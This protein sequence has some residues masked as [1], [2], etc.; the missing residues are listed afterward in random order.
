MLDAVN[1]SS[2]EARRYCTHDARDDPVLH[3]KNV[4][5][6]AI[7]PIGPQMVAGFG[8]DQLPGDTHPE[9]RLANAAFEHVTHAQL[10]GD[11]F[12]VDNLAFV[13]ERRIAGD[14]E[15]GAVARQRGGD[16]LNDSVAEVVL[17]RIAAE[18]RERQN[19]DRRPVGERQGGSLTV[20]P[21]CDGRI[22]TLVAREQAGKQITTP[23]NGLHDAMAAILQDFTDISDALDKQIVRYG[24]S[25][26]DLMEQFLFRDR[27]PRV[28]CQ[29]AQ[30]L[31]RLRPKRERAPVAFKRPAV[32][33]KRECL[34]LEHARKAQ[35]GSVSFS[36]ETGAF[37]NFRRFSTPFVTR[38]L[39]LAQDCAPD[40]DRQWAGGRSHAEQAFGSEGVAGRR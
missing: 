25:G 31:H 35:S 40:L 21:D 38:N 26:P 7:E 28:F 14:D 24:N 16:V 3:V 15:E 23:G 4:G 1:L 12:D 18:V 20:R 39:R 22:P 30:Y 17:I 5:D 10:A 8:F 11:L 37:V 32:R 6:I 19:S 34:K 9:T 2:L 13:G 29:I 36:I 27:P 33:I